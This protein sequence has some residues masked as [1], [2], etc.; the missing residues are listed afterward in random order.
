MTTVRLPSR[1]TLSTAVAVTFVE[2]EPAVMVTFAGKLSDE[3]VSLDK[4]IWRSVVR[5]PGMLTVTLKVDPSWADAGADNE[6]TR[7]S[8]SI[9]VVWAEADANPE[10]LA[11]TVVRMFPSI[12]E[13]LVARAVKSAWV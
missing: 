7:V 8:L 1:S 6:M 2:V 11:V 3:G 10:P 12:R 9:V 5:V 13:S 4:L